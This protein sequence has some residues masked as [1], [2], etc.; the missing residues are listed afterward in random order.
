MPP[1]GMICSDSNEPSS[2]T[3]I[4]RKLFIFSTEKIHCKLISIMEQPY[5]Q[6]Y[7]QAFVHSFRHNSSFRQKIRNG[8]SRPLWRRQWG[9]IVKLWR[10]QWGGIVK[11]SKLQ[12]FVTVNATAAD[13]HKSCVIVHCYPAAIWAGANTI[14]MGTTIGHVTGPIR[15]L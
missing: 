8:T 15:H 12:H 3:W 5:S 4:K 1:R 11:L 10:R 14:A 2:C 9:G 13:G 7:V 6:P